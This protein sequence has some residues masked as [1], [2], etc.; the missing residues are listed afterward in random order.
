MVLA[1]VFRQ[2][3]AIWP[4]NESFAENTAIVRIDVLKELQVSAIRSPAA[5]ACFV[6]TKTSGQ[7]AAVKLLEASQFAQTDWNDNKVLNFDPGRKPV[8]G[9][10]RKLRQSLHEMVMQRLTSTL[11]TLRGSV[12]S[13]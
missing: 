4:A 9:A 5:G 13:P 12:T 7:D 1:E 2:A 10:P 6:L 11:P 3:R 8:V